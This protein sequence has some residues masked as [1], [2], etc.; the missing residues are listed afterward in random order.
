MMTNL[1]FTGIPANSTDTTS[2][3][4]QRQSSYAYGPYCGLFSLEESANGIKSH[5]NPVFKTVIGNWP[6]GNLFSRGCYTYVS[7]PIISY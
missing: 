7:D 6:H 5:L 4:D 2:T 1:P 3:I